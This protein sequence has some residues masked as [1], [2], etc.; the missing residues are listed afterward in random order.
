MKGL[1]GWSCVCVLWASLASAQTDTFAPNENLM[2][3][4]VPAVPMS[5]V[6]GAQHY[7]N[8]RAADLAS[9]NPVRREML[10][11]TRFADSYQ[12]HIVKMPGGARTQLTFYPEPAVG[13][14][15]NPRDG[16]SFIFLKDVGGGEF[17]QLY[18]FDLDYR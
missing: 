18:R 16:K 12:V 6:E 17:Y 10:I 7:S 4:G 13:A 14:Q 5:V 1:L 2:V 15:F 8:F 11:L 9:W 3:E